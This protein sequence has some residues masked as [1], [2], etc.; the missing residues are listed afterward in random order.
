VLG[1]GATGSLIK[2]MGLA[3]TDPGCSQPK[4]VSGLNTPLSACGSARYPGNSPSVARGICAGQ[5]S[6][7]FPTG[8]AELRHQR[9]QTVGCIGTVNRVLGDHLRRYL[10]SAATLSRR[11]ARARTHSRLIAHPIPQPMPSKPC[12]IVSFSR[13]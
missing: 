1:A 9:P 8:T 3:R 6:I 7:T 4:M 11:T 13:S 2:T 5:R 12:I 10:I